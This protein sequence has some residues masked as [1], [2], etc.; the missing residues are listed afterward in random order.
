MSQEVRLNV[1]ERVEC[2]RLP[3]SGPSPPQ[4]AAI[5]VFGE[6]SSVRPRD[7][8]IISGDLHTVTRVS[9]PL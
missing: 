8:R 7:A 3:H 5:K 9:Q 6:P 4:A 1:Q 2:L